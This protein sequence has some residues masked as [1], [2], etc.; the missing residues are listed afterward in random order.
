MNVGKYIYSVLT[1]DA[2]VSALVSTRIYPVVIAEK[3][4]FPAIAYTV[5]TVPKDRQKDKASDYDTETV[6]F[7]LWA[8]IQQGADAYTKTTE[9]DAAIRA[10]LDFVE[11][12]AAGVTVVHCH[13][14]GSKDI[15]S[16]D[17]ML[18]GK[19]SVYTFITRN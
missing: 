12:T 17:R 1:A 6:T 14:D 16:E 10:A 13:F 4:T 11:G 5:S 7:H 9:M 2:G 3:A 8:D 15:V 18:I 19:E